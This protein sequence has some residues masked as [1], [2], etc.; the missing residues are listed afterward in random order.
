MITHIELAKHHL[1]EARIVI[2]EKGAHEAALEC[3]YAIDEVIRHVEG[4]P[5]PGVR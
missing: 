4:M 2:Y 3:I 1:R 5:P